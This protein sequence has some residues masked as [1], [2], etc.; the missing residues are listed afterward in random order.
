MKEYNLTDNYFYRLRHR[1]SKDLSV[2]H[3]EQHTRTANLTVELANITMEGLG[4]HS[5]LKA[6]DTLIL[7]DNKITGKKH[8]VSNAPNCSWAVLNVKE[9]QER[10]VVL[11][12]LKHAQV[13]LVP[14]MGMENTL[15][16]HL[17]FDQAPVVSVCDYQDPRY[18]AVMRQINLAFISIHFGLSEGLFDDID[19]YTT[20]ANINCQYEKQKIKLQLSVMKLLWE[21]AV[22]EFDSAAVGDQYWHYSHTLYSF[23]KQC[24]VDI[25]KLTTEITGSGL[26]EINHVNH[27]RYRD[28]LVY[29]SHMRNLYFC[30]QGNF[31]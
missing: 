3:I 11:V 4:T 28:A 8:W 22:R 15:T 30:L 26:Y 18:Q 16:G 19:Q 29:S 5:T 24:L 7:T 23:A 21:T 1:A 9:G 13:E 10:T 27:Q 17:Y 20:Q 2:A 25:I 31:A 14:T 6:D 12:D